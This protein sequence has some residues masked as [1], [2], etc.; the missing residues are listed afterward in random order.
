MGEVTRNGLPADVSSAIEAVRRSS[1]SAGSF[2]VRFDIFGANML[3]LIK[4]ADVCLEAFAPKSRWT[5]D[6]DA[7]PHV[8]TGE[9]A[10]ITYEARVV[11]KWLGPE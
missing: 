5:T 6:I 8:V 4:K 3:E 1:D 11:A 10:T 2:T 9:G 7:S